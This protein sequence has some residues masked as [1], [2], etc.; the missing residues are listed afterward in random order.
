MSNDIDCDRKEFGFCNKFNVTLDTINNKYNLNLIHKWINS[1]MEKRELVKY[2]VESN[3]YD[4][5]EYESTNKDGFYSNVDEALSRF[6]IVKND[7]KNDI[8]NKE[9]IFNRG[10]PGEEINVVLYKV[11]GFTKKAIKKY[12]VRLKVEEEEIDY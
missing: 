5:Y 3:C 12:A 11:N 10:F 6:N 2:I 4:V 1:Q 8:K 7:I 9:N